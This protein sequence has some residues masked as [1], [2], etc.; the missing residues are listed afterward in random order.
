MNIHTGIYVG[1]V[2]VF[3]LLIIAK[4]QKYQKDKKNQKRLDNMM[5]KLDEI[6]KSIAEMKKKRR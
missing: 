5:V 1:F 6:A 4:G 2:I 3:C